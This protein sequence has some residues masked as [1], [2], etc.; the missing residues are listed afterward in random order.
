MSGIPP[1]IDLE[2]A[3]L[4]SAADRAAVARALDRAC[5]E[6]GAFAVSGHGIDDAVFND[7]YGELARFFARPQ[8]EKDFC[9][10]ATGF[11]MSA[12][13]YTPYGYSGLLEENAY[14]YMG[15]PDRPADYVE[16]Y[17]TGRLV[18][19]DA[20][21][22]PFNGDAGGLSLRAALKRYYRA[23]DG[24]SSLLTGL[25][26]IPLDLP[27]DFFAT[28]T[29]QSND[30]MRCH[31]YPARDPSFA[32]DQGMGNHTD[33]SLITLLT[34]TGPG[35]RIRTLD[36]EWVEP[37]L[38]TNREVIVN[39]GDLLTHWSGNRYPATPH[40]V[41][42]TSRP[43]YSIAFFKLTNEDEMVSV[44]NKQMDALFGR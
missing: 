16:K 4:G 39:V 28:H 7:V 12:D 1:M 9:R 2:P 32:N 6:T 29:D 21:P 18:L 19:D 35:V 43:R 20:T 41:V 36:G 10:L 33:G 26:T 25:F 13:E 15:E 24:L 14:A 22:L 27:P 23:A 38:P 42:L 40:G 30:S 5:R 31:L 44:G 11:T 34:H 17:S 37:A 8:A 3:R